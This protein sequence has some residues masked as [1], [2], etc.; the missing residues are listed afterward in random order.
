M[1]AVTVVFGSQCISKCTVSFNLSFH[2]PVSIA[3][4]SLAAFLKLALFILSWFMPA[5]E[6]PF[7]PTKG[8]DLSFA[9]VANTLKLLILPILP[10]TLLDFD[11][12]ITIASPAHPFIFGGPDGTSNN[13]PLLLTV[14]STVLHF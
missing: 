13:S 1:Y 5:R 8:A 7:L 12:T 10:T 11:S 4:V 6:T 9:R 3:V 2:P 14:P